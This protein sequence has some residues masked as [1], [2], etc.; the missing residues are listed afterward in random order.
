MVPSSPDPPSPPSE[1]TL[2]PM[3]MGHIS[4][5]YSN[6]LCPLQVIAS[7]SGDLLK[8]GL[9]RQRSGLVYSLSWLTGLNC[10]SPCPLHMP[11][12]QCISHVPL[13]PPHESHPPIRNASEPNILGVLCGYSQMLL[14]HSDTGHV[15]ITYRLKIA[16]RGFFLSVHSETVLPYSKYTSD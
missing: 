16:N 5:V 9:V 11:I 4:E 1:N 8:E 13:M 6:L 12:A 10:L 7:F 14:F 15:S 2:S 3:T